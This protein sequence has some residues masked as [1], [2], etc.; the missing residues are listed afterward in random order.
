MPDEIYL[1]MDVLPRISVIDLQ[2][3]LPE[4]SVCLGGDLLADSLFIQW[5]EVAQHQGCLVKRRAWR[6]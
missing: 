4:V 2:E 3:K 1:S 5:L 6:S